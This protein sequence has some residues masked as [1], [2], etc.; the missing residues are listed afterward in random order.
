MSLLETRGQS[1]AVDGFVVAAVPLADTIA[2]ATGGGSLCFGAGEAATIHDGAILSAC[3]APDEIS[4][5]T[6]GDDGALWQTSRDGR[7]TQLIA[8]SRWIDG[9]AASAASGLIAASSGKSVTVI[10]GAHQHSLAHASSVTGLA[11]ESKGKRL[12]ASHYGGVSLWWA[13]NAGAQPTK[14]DWKGSHIGVTWSPDGRFVVSAM[15]DAALHGWR[16]PEKIDMRMSGYPAKTKSLA[17]TPKGK[18][19]ATS[20]AEDV[21]CWPFQAKDGPMGKTPQSFSGAGAL[22]TCVAAHP[23]VDVLASGYQN[24]SVLLHRMEDGAELVVANVGPSPVSA[25]A[26]S[27]DGAVLGFGCEDGQIGLVPVTP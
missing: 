3:L 7:R 1:F 11:F 10:D 22:V 26:F 20:G 19:L 8:G 2:F 14:L 15:Q 9:L 16:L 27:N 6:G 13:G 12:A 17:W 5:L 21:V 25:I 18:W 4:V 23:R 24:G